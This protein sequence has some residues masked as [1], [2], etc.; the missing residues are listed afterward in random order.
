MCESLYESIY[1]KINGNLNVKDTNR[2]PVKFIRC[3]VETN[4]NAFVIL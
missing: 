1:E 4:E 3:K 2:M